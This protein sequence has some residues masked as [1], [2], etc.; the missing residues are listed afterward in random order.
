MISAQE[1]VRRKE[2]ITNTL[3]VITPTGNGYFVESEQLYTREEFYNR[4][5]LPIILVS[6][7]K[8]NA[9]ASKNYLNTD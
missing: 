8:K 1:Y 2:I 5:P 4:Y 9:D 3:F 6:N 7:N